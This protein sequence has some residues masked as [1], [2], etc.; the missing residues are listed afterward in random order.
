MSEIILFEVTARAVKTAGLSRFLFSKKQKVK[1]NRLH[2]QYCPPNKIFED[3]T[4]G[5]EVQHFSRI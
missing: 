3:T 5:K 2:P 4:G 1:S